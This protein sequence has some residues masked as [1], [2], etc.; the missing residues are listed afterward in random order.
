LFAQDD[1]RVSRSLTLQLGLRWDLM[2]PPVQ[3]DN[4]QS[5]FSVADGL[6]H[7]ASPDNR[8][9]DRITHYDYFAPRLGLAYTPDSGKTAVRAAFGISYFA[10]NFGANGGTSERNY[11]FFQQIDLVSPTSTTPFRSLNDGLPTFTSVPLAPTLTPP[12]GFAVFYIPPDFREDKATMWNIGLQREVGWSTV[13]DASY[14]ATRG[15]NI[16]RSYN[17]NVPDPGPGAVQERRP[18]FA[19]APTLST[20]NQRDGDGKSWYDALQLKADKRF[21]HGFQMLVSYTYSK[22]E[23]NVTPAGLHPS[24]AGVRMPALSKAIDIPHIFVVSATYELPLG[25]GKRFLSTSTGLAGALAEGWTASV[26]T[27]YHSG[28]PLDARVSASRLNTGSGNW[29]DL[30]C[31]TVGTPHQVDKWFDTTCFADPAQY[32]F[33]NYRIGD[34]RGPTVFNTDA[35]LF[36]K[37][38]IGKRAFELRIDAFNVFNRAH[39]ANPNVTFGNS[40]FGRVSATRLTSREIQVGARVLF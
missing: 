1:F 9:P 37:T 6:I 39:F 26:I 16:F 3:T 13:I 22:T 30:T 31:S 10:D 2:T 34:V 23:D 24:L 19:I 40:A 15:T 29:A 33:G 12:A 38:S 17:V 4:R 20:I 8:G 28:D 18:Y 11:P 36:K 7:V 21:T 5:N 35:S 14:V 25:R 27:N 32:Q